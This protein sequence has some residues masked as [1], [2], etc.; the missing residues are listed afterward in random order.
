MPT[1]VITLHLSPGNMQGTASDSAR[2]GLL[3]LQ[4]LSPAS[5]SQRGR[6]ERLGRRTMM[7]SR[8]G[9]VDRSLNLNPDYRIVDKSVSSCCASACQSLYRLTFRRSREKGFTVTFGVSKS[10]RP[11]LATCISSECWSTS[12]SSKDDGRVRVRNGIAL[13]HLARPMPKLPGRIPHP[14]HGAR[15][16]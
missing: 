16:S 11:T 2:P 12:I 13:P 6:S 10:W 4:R 3:P 15:F 1:V 8:A 5:C 7:H 9:P 14:G